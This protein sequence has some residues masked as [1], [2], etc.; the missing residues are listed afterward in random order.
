M[1]ALEDKGS[2]AMLG[3]KKAVFQIILL[4]KNAGS[5]ENFSW[6]PQGQRKVNN[7]GYAFSHKETHH[8]SI[9]LCLLLEETYVVCLMIMH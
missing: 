6:V 5:T 3:E 1:C 2:I 8:T 9:H 4:T 7:N